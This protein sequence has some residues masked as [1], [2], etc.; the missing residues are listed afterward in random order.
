MGLGD[1]GVCWDSN[2]VC[3]H[4]ILDILTTRLEKQEEDVMGCTMVVSGER[5]WVSPN[6]PNSDTHKELSKNDITFSLLDK[7]TL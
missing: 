3:V 7:P 1:D 6:E 5:G 4:T 2:G